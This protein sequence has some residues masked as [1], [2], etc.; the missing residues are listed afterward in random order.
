MAAHA[1]SGCA[2]VTAARAVRVHVR[3]WACVRTRVRVGECVRVLCVQGGWGGVGGCACVFVCLYVCVRA[4]VYTRALSVC[5]GVGIYG[6]GCSGCGDVDNTNVGKVW[7]FEDLQSFQDRVV[8]ILDHG[9]CLPNSQ[10]CFMPP[11]RRRAV[12]IQQTT[13][14]AVQWQSNV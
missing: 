9:V 12:H 11:R 2:C 14:G 5:D 6:Y 1:V 4:S 3:V 8:C 7:N 13:V 10:V